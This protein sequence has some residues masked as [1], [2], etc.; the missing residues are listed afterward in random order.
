MSFIIIS[1][2]KRNSP[3][4]PWK[5]FPSICKIFKILGH[6]HVIFALIHKILTQ[7]VCVC[8]LVM[9]AS[10]YFQYFPWEAHSI[11]FP[12][13]EEGVVTS[14]LPRKTK[15]PFL[16][17]WNANT[18]NGTPAMPTPYPFCTFWERFSGLDLRREFRSKYPVHTRHIF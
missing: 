4:L 1:D 10:T 13:V 9:P 15:A 14:P 5:G 12:R 7:F 16:Y 6:T 8:N 3:N 18:Q 17:M 2:S 11:Y